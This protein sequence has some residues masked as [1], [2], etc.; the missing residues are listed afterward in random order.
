[1]QL[2]MI[3][4]T[5]IGLALQ[6][7]ALTTGQAE[8]IFDLDDAEGKKA[9][10]VDE[11]GVVAAYDEV[12][13]SSSDEEGAGAGL[14]E[15]DEPI[16]DS[17]EEEEVAVKRRE[18]ELDGM[19]EVYMQKR[20]ERDAKF[21]VRERR[22]LDKERSENWSGV[23]GQRTGE[24]DDSDVDSDDSD[25]D[26][27]KRGWE[28]MEV[29]K[30]EVDLSGSDDDEAEDEDEEMDG[31]DSPRPAKRRKITTTTTASSG[32]SSAARSSGKLVTKLTQL[33][34]PKASGSKRAQVWFAQDMFKNLVDLDDLDDDDAEGGKENVE[35]NGAGAYEALGGDVKMSGGEDND[36]GFEEVPQDEDDPTMWDV[37]DENIDELKQAQ[38][39]SEFHTRN[40]HKD[41]T[42]HLLPF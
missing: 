12:G 36:D 19:Y 1:M 42:L 25:A 18:M 40:P 9:R 20:M 37:Q 16:L 15:E 4:P 23:V 11:G 33:E 32:S 7:V 38:I 14:M 26:P 35:P 3:A 41:F 13:S 22:K 8:D 17:D 27:T 24:D 28:N 31:G 10:K 34:E 5:D 6:D 39:K 21:K 30:A 2:S 29:H